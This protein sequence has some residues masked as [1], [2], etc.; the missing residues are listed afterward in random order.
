[1]NNEQ[2]KYMPHISRFKAISHITIDENGKEW[3]HTKLVLPEE[4]AKK[5]SKDRQD[6][7]S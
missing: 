5:T 6:S 3:I 2:E 4:E 1:M 7:P